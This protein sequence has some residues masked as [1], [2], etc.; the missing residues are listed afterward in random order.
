MVV[1]P[2]G[3]ISNVS[4][5]SKQSKCSKQTKLITVFIANIISS[6]R[7]TMDRAAL[8]N[9]ALKEKHV[10]EMEKQTKLGLKLEAQIQLHLRP[11]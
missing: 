1:E 2:H 7:I 5:Q 8:C 6:S 4:E 11:S 10:V 9:S 3:H